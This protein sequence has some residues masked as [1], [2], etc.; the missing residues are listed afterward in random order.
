MRFTNG[1]RDGVMR[2]IYDGCEYR[3]HVQSGFLSEQNKANVSFTF[4]TDGVEIQIIEVL[5]VAYMASD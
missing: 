2:D 5:P 4:N 3:W 1:A